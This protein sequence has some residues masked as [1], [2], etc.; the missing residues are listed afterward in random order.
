MTD[1]TETGWD[2]L[3]QG[4]VRKLP[5]SVEEATTAEQALFDALTN[6]KRFGELACVQL[7]TIGGSGGKKPPSKEV[8]QFPRHML[9]EIDAAL[10]RAQPGLT[11]SNT[12]HKG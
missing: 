9:V 1:R 11:P 12:P 5:L 2:T 4:D 7:P 8:W 6:I 3:P 10:A